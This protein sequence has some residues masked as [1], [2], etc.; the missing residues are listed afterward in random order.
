MIV[1]CNSCQAKFKIADEK[2]L[3]KG[4][5]VRCTRCKTTFVVRRDAAPDPFA[6]DPTR[7]VTMPPREGVPPPPADYGEVPTKVGVFAAGVSATRVERTPRPPPLPDAGSGSKVMDY[8]AS[9]VTDPFAAAPSEDP[10]RDAVTLPPSRPPPAD[11]T[12]P[13]ETA[14]AF[15][16]TRPSGHPGSLAPDTSGVD[17][18]FRDLPGSSSEP[19]RPAAASG[20]DGELEAV[21]SPAD[22]SFD[23][24]S[25]EMASHSESADALNEVPDAPPGVDDPFSL[26]GT[27]PRVSPFTVVPTDIRPQQEV[28]RIPAARDGHAVQPRPATTRPRR[29][30]LVAAVNA[31]LFLL[32]GVVALVSVAV[33][34]NDGT[35]DAAALNPLALIARL[36]GSRGDTGL[37]TSDVTNGL[38][39]TANGRP[40]FYV[41][42]VVTQLG[43]E[44]AT[45][46]RVIVEIANRDGTVRKSEAFAGAVPTAE[47]MYKIAQADDLVALER[48]LNK[49]A[50]VIERGR[51]VAFA[52]VFYDYPEDFSDARLKVRAEPGGSAGTAPTGG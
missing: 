6:P 39:E 44:P 47:Q 14:P 41:R 31:R 3:P 19:A 34:A 21:S 30:P 18:A 25:F 27:V 2:V 35:F 12:G 7:P 37:V 33:D 9:T 10:F 51:P 38:Y 43:R 49:R 46:I 16:L 32:A 11:A 50:P 20:F 52:V 15:H 8:R 1:Q 17:D 45:P 48:D 28:I 40:V 36:G 22:G 23:R 29:R 13:A 24:S 5:K 4:V 26:P 42:G